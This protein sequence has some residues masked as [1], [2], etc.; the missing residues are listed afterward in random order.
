MADVSSTS[1]EDD[2]SLSVRAAWLHYGA[3]LT[4]AEVA[5]R[6]GVPSLK[7]HRLIA[8]ANR[9]GLVKITVDGDIGACLR[10]EERICAEYGLKS[11]E[12]APEIED[13][14]LPLRT[15][16]L[17]GA[18]FLRLALESGEDRI[19]GF[20]HGR[21]LAAVVNHLPRMDAHEVAC[22]SLLG[23]LT[24]RYSATPYDVIHRLA[25]RTGAE[26]YVL[27][28]PFFANSPEDRAVLLAQKGVGEIVDMGI[29]ATLRLVGIGSMESDA[30]ILSTGMVEESEFEELRRAGGVGELLG[31]IFDANG[32]VIETAISARTLSMAPEDIGRERTVAI[33]G[34]KSKIEAIKGV[35]ASGLIHGLITDER[36][37]NA[38]V[39]A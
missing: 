16:G 7:A 6:L 3:G 32:R 25:E 10:L 39:G 37:A 34:G 17:V 14:A 35:L 24:R 20:G 12:V 38:L 29:R 30:S 21:T 15:L 28:L 22:V 31:H 27:P 19:I 36:T 23:G 26:A 4:Q 11:C 9:E 8:R 13:A 33:V 18:R 2:A 1:R 5:K